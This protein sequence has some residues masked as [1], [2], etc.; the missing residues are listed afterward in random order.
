VKDLVLG[1]YAA[2]R[3]GDD[4]TPFVAADVV[5]HVPGDHPTA[6]DWHGVAGIQRFM[7][8]SRTRYD[9]QQVETLDVLVG[10]GHV[11]VYNH[12]T[13]QRAGHA[14]LDN[15]TLHLL[16]IEHDRIAEIWFHNRNQPAV[17]AFWRD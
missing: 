15:F 3:N 6:G 10:E 12:A 4:L 2:L 16:R 7:A 13:G 17:D 9:A 1:Y 11:A 5:L 14:D 8:E